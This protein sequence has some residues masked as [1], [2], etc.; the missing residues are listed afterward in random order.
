MRALVTGG[1]G[2]IGSH[3]CEALL[4]RGDA[5]FVLD[6]LS[7]GRFENIEHLPA[8]ECIIDTVLNQDI[9][10]DLVRD[11]DVV[12]HLA[13]TVGV[14]LVVN[15][16]VQTIVNNIRGTEIVLE[17]TC[18]YRRKLLLTSTSEVYGKGT[19]EVFSEDDD[20]VIGPTHLIRWCYAASKAIDEF[21]ALAYWREKRHP[22]VVARLFNTVGPRQT[23]RYGMVI[24]TLVSQA[25]RAEPLTV[26]GDGQQSRCFTYVG[27]VVPALLTLMTR[28][29][30]NGEV[31]NI[32]SNQ[33]VTIEA[34]AHKIIERTGSK[35]SIKYVPYGEAYGPGYED[36]RHRAPCL[37]K[38]RAAIGYE[39][40]TLL[41][42]ILDS[43][44][45]DLRM[46][47]KTT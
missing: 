46:R 24:P 5:V 36:M 19:G 26:Y 27:D 15:H 33:R 2:F 17:E 9:V 25:L 16:P 6:D 23:G 40:R 37:K 41:D 42:A 34:L 45:D 38:I 39:P 35:S 31:Y 47:M 14:Q 10:R 44:I 13:A 3:L 43:V 1:A 7:T 4:A 29:D 32:G 20:R 18:R 30:V 8:L 28:S 22:I 11:V 21:L 12:Y